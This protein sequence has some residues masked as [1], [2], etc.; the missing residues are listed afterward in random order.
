[1]LK[2][3]YK[4]FQESILMNNKRMIDIKKKVYLLKT[5]IMK[6]NKKGIIII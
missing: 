5:I 4:S 3:Y 6:K 2:D 1:M